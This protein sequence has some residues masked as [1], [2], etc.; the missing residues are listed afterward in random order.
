MLRLVYQSTLFGPLHFEYS[1]AIV[2]VGSCRDNDLVLL[3]PSVQPYHCVLVFAET[4]LCLLPPQAVGGD[5]VLEPAP[6]GPRY[7]AGGTLQIG[8]L[9]FQ[10]ERSPNSV[11]V[12]EFRTAT[13]ATP[14]QTRE[15][16]WRA[17]FA[18]VPDE[19]RWLC[20][21]CRLRLATSQVHVLGLVGGRKYALCPK[22]SQT[23]ELIVPLESGRPG[24][25][26]R[27]KAGWRDLKRVCG[28][29]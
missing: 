15:G 4:S 29:V 11:A 28:R 12:P 6:A 20:G 22:C 27:L 18:A 16:Y 8:E 24:L 17:D 2:R 21:R 7:V 9:V 13:T 3:H 14:G 1:K 10:V 25:L 26:G 19:A 5:A 23:V